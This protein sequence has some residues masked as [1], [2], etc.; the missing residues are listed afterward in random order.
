[1]SLEITKART[2]WSKVLAE[3]Y[4]NLEAY[5]K[6]NYPSEEK[7][8]FS[9]IQKQK[10]LKLAHAYNPISCTWEAKVGEFPWVPDKSE[11]LVKTVSKNQE[12]P[13]IQRYLSSRLAIKE[14]L[15]EAGDTGHKP[16]HNIYREWVQA[17]ALQ[18]ERKKI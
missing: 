17:P 11:L 6:Q 13:N 1:M 16:L 3:E 2:E 14:M 5:I 4:S 9:V 7:Q 18:K 12:N 15:K 8:T 10:C